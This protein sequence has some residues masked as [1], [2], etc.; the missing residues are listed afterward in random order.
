MKRK[1]KRREESSD[2]KL[3]RLMKKRYDENKSPRPTPEQAYII[4]RQLLGL[5]KRK[6]KR[7]K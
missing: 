4:G 2:L 1:I 7:R 3:L 6:L 5:P